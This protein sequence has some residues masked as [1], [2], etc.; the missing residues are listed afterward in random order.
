MR[1][2][3]VGRDEDAVWSLATSQSRYEFLGKC[4]GFLFDISNSDGLFEG[5]VHG[6]Y[7][8]V[9]GRGRECTPDG[10]GRNGRTA[11]CALEGSEGYYSSYDAE[12][13]YGE[14]YDLKF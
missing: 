4:G 3:H 10:H 14:G 7:V 12:Y 5:V 1:Q 8:L 13:E 6:A 9:E 2:D 11:R